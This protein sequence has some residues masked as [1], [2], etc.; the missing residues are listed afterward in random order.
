MHCESCG[1]KNICKFNG[2]VAI[3]FPGLRSITLRTIWVVCSDCGAARFAVP[4]AELRVLQ[5]AKSKVGNL[6]AS[7][8][9]LCQI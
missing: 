2:E 8:S 7:Q 9:R 6:A 1:A 5:T 4:D 3:P